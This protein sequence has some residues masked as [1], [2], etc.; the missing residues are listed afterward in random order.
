LRGR[1]DVELFVHA[2]VPHDMSGVAS[3]DAHVGGAASG[4]ASE[5][6]ASGP[7]VALE[8]ELHPASRRREKEKLHDGSRA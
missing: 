6:P 3:S 1:D 7:E 5:D 2:R 8:L 4:V